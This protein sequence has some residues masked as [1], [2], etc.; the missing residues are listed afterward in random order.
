[1]QKYTKKAASKTICICQI[2]DDNNF[3]NITHNKLLVLDA[4]M[5]C[6]RRWE[7]LDIHFRNNTKPDAFEMVIAKYLEILLLFTFC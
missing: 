7:S 5:E 6:F 3:R 2:P 4:L 1:M